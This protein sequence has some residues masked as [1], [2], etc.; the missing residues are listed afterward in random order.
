MNSTRGFSCKDN[1]TNM[2]IK[3]LHVYIILTNI[4]TITDVLLAP[5]FRD[6]NS[7]IQNVMDAS[8]CHMVS[9]GDRGGTGGGAG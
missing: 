4:H 9:V 8:L 2:Y 6:T 1:T 5:G 7:V 3:H